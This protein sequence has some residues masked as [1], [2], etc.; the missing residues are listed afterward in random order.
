MTPQQMES[1]M[2]A[3]QGG[4]LADN[5][6]VPAPSIADRDTNPLNYLGR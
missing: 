3:V 4:L 1:R 6:S 2:G 5:P